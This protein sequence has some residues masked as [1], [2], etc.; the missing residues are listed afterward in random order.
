M[1]QEHI[2]HMHTQVLRCSEV[3]K[4]T[5]LSRVT[6]WRLERRGEFPPRR[7]L[8]RNAVGWTEAEIEDGIATRSKLRG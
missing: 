7:Q 5:G 4:R 1:P 6:I 3:C 8:S 2:D